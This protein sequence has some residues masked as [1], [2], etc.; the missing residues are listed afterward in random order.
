MKNILYVLSLLSFGYNLVN[1]KLTS[2]PD[3]H[4]TLVNNSE[5]SQQPQQASSKKPT[6]SY[7]LPPSAGKWLYEKRVDKTGST[8]YKASNTSLNVL[9]FRFPYEGGSSA[10][11]TLRHKN[12][13]TYLYLEVSRGQFNRT[14]Q[15]GTA[16]IAFDRKP[17]KNYSFSAAENGRA[18]I[19]FFDNE[20]TLVSQMKGAQKMAIDIEF[21]AQGRRTIEFSTADLS[22]NH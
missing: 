3:A 11:L 20:A 17:A 22:W 1:G 9:N 19:I 12:D 2:L 13:L 14:F 7:T 16:R 6:A 4:L 15:G 10:T 18:N 21:Y 5:Q 8:V